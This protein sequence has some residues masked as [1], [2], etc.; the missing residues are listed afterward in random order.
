MTIVATV[1]LLTSPLSSWCVPSTTQSPR[2]Q[3]IS[4]CEPSPPFLS[5]FNQCMFKLMFSV[6]VS[7]FS[8]YSVMPVCWNTNK[9]YLFRLIKGKSTMFYLL[10]LSDHTSS[11]K[12]FRSVLTFVVV[13]FSIVI[14]RF[15]QTFAHFSIVFCHL[16][17]EN[18]MV[19]SY[20]VE[21]LNCH[22][23]LATQCENKQ[24]TGIKTRYKRRYNV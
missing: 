3:I 23:L 21:R 13:L 4:Q 7:R 2:V 12:S 24:K 17:A 9:T 14:F 20:I 5:I 1:D 8:A 16:R 19:H 6:L 10:F 22:I 15:P 18:F 11:Y